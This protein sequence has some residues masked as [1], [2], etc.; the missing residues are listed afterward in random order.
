MAV[1]KHDVHVNTSI[2]YVQ[3]F[4]VLLSSCETVWVS[5]SFCACTLTGS[6]V[7]LGKDET[8]W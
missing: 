6:D 7:C 5:S 2:L 3:E 1:L 8:V 4:L